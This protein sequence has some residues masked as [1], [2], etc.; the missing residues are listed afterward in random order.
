[1]EQAMNKYQSPY[2]MRT[3][4]I[5]V[6]KKAFKYWSKFV[7]QTV[8]SAVIL[9]IVIACENVEVIANSEIWNRATEMVKSDLDVEQMKNGFEWGLE[10]VK[11]AVPGIMES[12]PDEMSESD[13]T[14]DETNLGIT[15]E[16]TKVSE[17]DPTEGMT[18]EEKDIY[19]IVKATT[20]LRPLNGEITSPFGDRVDPITNNILYIQGLILLRLLVHR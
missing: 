8:I 12:Q 18:Q 19:N 20:I 3:K 10:Y 17:V 16:M 4:K 2:R 13:E 14:G 11:T 1:M 9:T 15:E 7:R 5:E 6:N